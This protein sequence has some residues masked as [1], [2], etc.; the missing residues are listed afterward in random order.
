M[1]VGNTSPYLGGAVLYRHD[2][3]EDEREQNQQWLKL[4]GELIFSAQNLN[5]RGGSE[6]ETGDGGGAAAATAAC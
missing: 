5:N 4:G 2:I 1:P 3:H 6:A